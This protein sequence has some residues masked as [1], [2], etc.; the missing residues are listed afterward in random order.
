MSEKSLKKQTTM[1]TYAHVSNTTDPIAQTFRADQIEGYIQ[2][3]SPEFVTVLGI[4]RVQPSV[5]HSAA[6]SLEEI[7][8]CLIEGEEYWAES[9][10]GERR[11]AQF[12]PNTERQ[13]ELCFLHFSHMKD[14][15]LD[16]TFHGSF[17]WGKKGA[18]I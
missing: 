2:E 11:W 17:K 4:Y 16:D 3:F 14:C 5:Y 10:V 8:D 15:P 6:K 1:L 7:R 12:P 9:L 18:C 13:F